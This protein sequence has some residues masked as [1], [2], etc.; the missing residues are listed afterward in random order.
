MKYNKSELSAILEKELKQALGAPGTEIS[1]IRLRNLQYYKAEATG[2][3][4]G[5]DIPDR[6]SIVA[7]D[8]ADTIEWMMPSLLKPFATS[9]DAMELEARRPEKASMA[10]MASEYLRLIFWKRNRGFS[11]LYN[12]FKD[13]LIQKVGFTKVVWEEVEEDV[14]ESYSGLLATQ[15]QDMMQSNEISIIEQEAYLETIQGQPIQLY[16]IKVKRVDR[17]GQCKVMPCPPEEM[18]VHPRSRYGE[19]LSFIAHVFYKTKQ[20]LEADGYDTKNI[21]SEDGWGME[22]IE[23]ASTQ[24]PWFFDGSDGEMQRYQCSECYIKLDQDG[25]GIAEWRRVFL[26]GGTVMEDEKVDDHPFVY[27][28][29][30]PM[31]H[32]FFGMCPADQA[33]DPQRLRTSLLRAVSD[34][35]YLTVNKRTEVV[36]G[37]VNMDDLLNSRPGGVVRVKQL[38]QMQPFNQ[39]SLDSSAWQMVEWAEKWNEQ[40]TGFTSYSK[41]LTSDS[42]NPTATGVVTITDKGDQRTELMARVAAETAVRVLF[43]KMLKCICRYQQ[44]ADQVELF[45]Q[46]IEIDPREWVDAFNVNINIGLGTGNKDRAA[47]VMQS[48]MQIQQPMIVGGVL[49][50]QAAIMAARKYA[51]SAG[52]TAPETYFPDAVP[53]QPRPDPEQAKMQAQM[54][55]EQGKAQVTMQ[56]EQMKA[57]LAMKL[58]AHEQEMQAQQNQHQ[59]MLDE[60]RAQ[61]QSIMQAQIEEQKNQ[62]EFQKAEME[63][64][65]A[66]W[67]AQLESD[68]KIVVAK[69]SANKSVENEYSTDV[70][71]GQ[72][73]SEEEMI[74]PQVEQVNSQEGN[75]QAI[76]DTVNANVAELINNQQIAQQQMLSTMLSALISNQK[77][78]QQEIL[79]AINR[80]KTLVRGPDGKVIGSK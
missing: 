62:K 16:N 77:I 61:Q 21:S 9:Q 22:Q 40:R 55:I 50:P 37:Q 39:G 3:L 48:V 38:G 25:D 42:L 57:D 66:K 26:I 63:M 32:V 11:L 13:A 41:G 46:W 49:P 65:L 51:E 76:S 14:E 7:S 30:I 15:I 45:G 43:E 67:K 44:K 56:V 27:F 34:N 69:I 78:A 54:Q 4:A 19:P 8:V 75:L 58:Q 6:S 47:Q 80:P 68:T 10:K 28:C 33:L 2:E 31:P 24:T 36:E 18:R 72:E 71:M 79:S 64:M 52:V 1:R 60:N 5:P 29:P 53:P 12:W 70:S 17:R 73:I 35:V 59:N 23:R 74:E 20:D